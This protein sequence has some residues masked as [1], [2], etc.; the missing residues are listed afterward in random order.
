MGSFAQY[1]VSF[2]AVL[3][4]LYTVFLQSR[5]VGMQQSV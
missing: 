4:V 1:V 2:E 5:L 3:G